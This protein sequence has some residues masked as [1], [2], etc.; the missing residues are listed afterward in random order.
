MANRLKKNEVLA[1]RLL[2][3]KGELSPELIEYHHFDARRNT[4]S[5]TT[6]KFLT[7]V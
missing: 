1:Y 4:G 7:N 6:I 3:Q 2:R 5:N